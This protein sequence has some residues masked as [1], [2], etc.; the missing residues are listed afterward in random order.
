M[1]SRKRRERRDVVHC[2]GYGR[3]HFRPRGATRRGGIRGSGRLSLLS[4]TSLSN[5]PSDPRIGRRC[6]CE[7][8]RVSQITCLAQAPTRSLSYG[9]RPSRPTP[10]RRPPWL[11]PPR[12]RDS[13]TPR[14]PQTPARSPSSSSAGESGAHARAAGA[15]QS[16][17]AFGTGSVLTASAVQ[18]QEDQ[19]RWERAC[20]LPVLCLQVALHVAADQRSCCP[21]PTVSLSS[22]LRRPVIPLSLIHTAPVDSYVQELEARLLHMEDVFRQVAPVI[23]VLEK[24]N[25]GVQLPSSVCDAVRECYVDLVPP[26]ADV[27]PVVKVKVKDETTSQGSRSATNSPSAKSSRAEGDDVSESFGQLALDEHGHLRW[28]GGSSTMSLIQSFRALTSSPLHRISPMEEDP[29]SPGP[30]ATK[31]YFPASVFFGKVHALP[32]PEEVEYPERDLADKL[33]SK[34]PV[35]HTYSLV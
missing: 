15:S 10:P 29:H 32:G 22:R 11:T 16:S 27:Q 3:I 23:D 17:A 30:S 13:T 26:P 14:S 18:A 21:E 5:R 8:C 4:S 9:T 34:F 2:S 35:A 19:M 24:S 31:L 28:I 33:V 20:L 7:P 6:A 1:Y 12:R 25:S